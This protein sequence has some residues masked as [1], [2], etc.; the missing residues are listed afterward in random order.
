MA[1]PNHIIIFLTREYLRAE[2]ARCTKNESELNIRINRDMSRI[3]AGPRSEYGKRYGHVL[4]MAAELAQWREYRIELGA[5]L[6][7]LDQI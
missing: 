4:D 1:C 5:T 7:S 2:Q 6:W 3:I